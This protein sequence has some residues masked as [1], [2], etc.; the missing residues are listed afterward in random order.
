MQCQQCGTIVPDGTPFCPTCGRQLTAPQPAAYPPQQPYAPAQPAPTQPFPVQQPGYPPAAPQAPYQQPAAY[1]PQQPYQPQP[2]QPYQPQPAPAPVPVKKKRTGLV[3][4]IIIAVVLLIAAAAVVALVLLPSSASKTQVPAGAYAP[5]VPPTSAAVPA[6]TAIDT[7][8]NTAAENAVVAFYDAI[9][10]GQYAAVTALVTP[11]TKS[12]IDPGAFEGWSKTTF[13][14][15][16][17]V[18]DGDTA[19]VYGRESVRHFGSADRGVKFTLLRQGGAWLIQTWQAVDEA[20]VNGVATSSGSGSGAASLTTAS[21]R[22]AVSS[23]LQARQVGDGATIRMLTTAAFQTAHGDVWLD[24]VDNTPYFTAF[25]IK[26]VKKSG[27]AYVVTVV[28]QWNSGAETAT[29]TVVDEMGSI[30]VDSWT[31]K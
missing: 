15:A 31:S 4:G 27:A 12:V 7:T 9:N 29:Y 16:R 6:T 18:V 28:E 22:D 8:D 19:L 23:L 25:A 1:A 30:L 13:E 21:A 5:A 2:Q 3:V 11:D 24:G 26:S 17:S 14:I 20:T 10:S